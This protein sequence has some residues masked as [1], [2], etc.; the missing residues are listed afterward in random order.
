MKKKKKKKKKKKNPGSTGILTLDPKLV[1]GYVV[2][3]YI[4]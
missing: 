1:N 3:I 4:E 2:N